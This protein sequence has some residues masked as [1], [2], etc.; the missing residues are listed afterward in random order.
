MPHGIGA[1]AE[2][3]GKT[4]RYRLGIAR[5]DIVNIQKNGS[6]AEPDRHQSDSILPMKDWTPGHR[7]STI[8][9]QVSYP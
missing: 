2:N 4:L 5:L 6:R 8:S 1:V 7:F 9:T 3:G